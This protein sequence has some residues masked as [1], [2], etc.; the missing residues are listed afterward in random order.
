[1]IIYV[2]LVWHTFAFPNV[3][4][5]TLEIVHTC[6][7]MHNANSYKMLHDSQKYLKYGNYICSV[8]SMIT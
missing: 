2:F 7:S 3:Y 8:M 5:I 1:M 6:V 4:H